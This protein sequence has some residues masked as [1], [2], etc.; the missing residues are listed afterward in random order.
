MSEPVLDDV[1]RRAALLRWGLP[2]DPQAVEHVTGLVV[3]AVGTVIVTRG[4]LQLTGFPQIGGKTLHVAHVLWGGLAMTVAMVLL[5]SFAGPVVRPLA[6]FLGGVG[7]GLFIDEV[8]KFLTND[9][10]YFF[11]PAPM[12][13]YVTLMLVVIVTD[14]LHGR[15]RHHPAE[16]LAGAADHAVAGL[17]GGLSPGRRKHATQLL[18]R[19][20]EAP[21]AAQI[22]ALLAAIPDDHAEAPDPIEL[23]RS[24]F[25]RMLRGVVTRRWATRTTAALIVVLV[26]AAPLTLAVHEAR[27][28]TVPVWVT[29]GVAVSVALTVLASG[30]GVT[31]LRRDRARAFR[32]MRGAVLADLLLTQVAL[33][34]VEP[35]LATGGLFVAVLALGVV[36]AEQ[37]RLESL[38]LAVTDTAR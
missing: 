19:G 29:V 12:I 32:W 18:A 14:V 17:V 11:K 1:A 31:L 25:R 4:Y 22:E 9:N 24:R 30:R 2:R 8:G 36:A 10:D 15:R 35:W 34:Y 27:G 20:R 5:L 33:F 13:I 3:T 7:L 28:G 6:A 37:H 16:Y 26:A 38:R 21:G 23:G